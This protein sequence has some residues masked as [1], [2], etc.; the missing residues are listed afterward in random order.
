[1][2]ATRPLTPLFASIILA[3]GCSAPRPG[4]LSPEARR[5]MTAAQESPSSTGNQ[6]YE[7]RVHALDSRPAPLFRYERRVQTVQQ[8]VVSTHV[9]YDPTGA[10]VVIQSAAHTPKYELVRADLIHGQTGVT[11]SAEVAA[12]NIVFTS[13]QGGR[14]STRSE[15]LRDP[16]VSGPTLF[17]YIL[18]HW[19]ELTR[20]A[21]LPVR[22]AVLERNETIGFTLELVESSTQGRTVIR[23]KPSSLLV[24]MAIS[25]TFFEFETATR[26]IL[27]Y[28]GRV[29]PLESVNGRLQTLDARVTYGFV[30]PDFR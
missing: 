28:T 20:G 8:D 5:T 10:V 21:S 25:P 12:R 1:M 23:M 4:T 26:K 13:N 7:G 17:G 29:P 14:I 22:F 24:R 30:A 16:V 19:D 18:A 2:I 15:Q 3:A 9:T 11:A 6:V 27:E